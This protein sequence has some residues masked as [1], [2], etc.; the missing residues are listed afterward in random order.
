MKKSVTPV[1]LTKA[2]Y[3]RYRGI[4][5]SGVTRYIASGVIIPTRTGKIN[6]VKADESIDHTKRAGA[7]KVVRIAPPESKADSGPL[8]KLTLMEART[9]NEIC[10]AEK[11]KAEL[12]KL[13]GQLVD[14]NEVIEASY[15]LGRM[16]KEV[17][18]QIPDRLSAILANESEKKEI[19]EI[20]KKEI[21]GVLER[22]SDSNKFVSKTFS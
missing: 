3:A 16:V 5:A 17:F 1:F 10:K 2:E 14:K 4:E 15:N 7:A 9:L 11:S 19:H 20:L 6:R 22:L 18:L 8:P 13:K 21:L 12:M